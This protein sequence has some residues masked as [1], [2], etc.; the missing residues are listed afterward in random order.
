MRM[1]ESVQVSKALKDVGINLTTVNAEEEFYNAT[2]TIPTTTADS[3][4]KVNVETSKLNQTANPE[5][6]RKIIGDTFMRIA[7]REISKLGFTNVEDVYLAQGTLRPDIIESGSPH[8]SSTAATI[9]THHNDTNL[10]RELRNLGRVVEP[11]ADYHKDEVRKLGKSLGLPSHLIERHP[12]PGP[13]LAVR[14]ICSDQNS[15][16]HVDD[17]I[18][19]RT[20]EFV[21][22][23]LHGASSS[24]SSKSTEYESVIQRS[25]RNEERS[26]IENIRKKGIL[27]GV[28]LPFKTVGVQGDCRTYNYPCALY[29][30]TKDGSLDEVNWDELFMLAK[31]IPRVEH[32]INR[33]VFIINNKPSTTINKSMKKSDVTPTLMTPDVIHQLQQADSVVTNELF[34]SDSMSK[35][36]QVPVILI[37]VGF[38]EGASH[39]IVIRTIITN[40]FMTGRAAHPGVDFPVSVLQSMAHEILQI[41]GIGR[42]LYDLTSKPPGTTEWE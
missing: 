1:E 32:N 8:I 21:H 40:D 15:Q 42:V 4:E 5:E 14:I 9:K 37:P 7:Q 35:L 23:L 2:T 30:D 17:D 28:V 6:K 19:S 29:Y 39:S 27:N 3:S 26:I 33:V 18:I 24:S 13:G 11:L 25:F 10:V 16:Q 20:N 34:K 22:T 36:S 12:F 31:F 41:P 38:E